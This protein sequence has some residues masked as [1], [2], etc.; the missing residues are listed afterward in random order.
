[1]HVLGSTGLIF[2]D[3]SVTL[4]KTHEYVTILLS[5]SLLC[6]YLFFCCLSVL[7]VYF[8]LSLPYLFVSFSFSHFYYFTVL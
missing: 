5:P 4:G 3:L 6:H 1:M 2:S 7:F 8:S